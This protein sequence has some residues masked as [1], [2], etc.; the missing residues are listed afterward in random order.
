MDFAAKLRRALTA[1]ELDL[2]YNSREAMLDDIQA[3]RCACVAALPG[4]VALLPLAL[5]ARPRPC[6]IPTREPP[7]L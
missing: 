1:K 2:E 3:A 7:P 4:D 6:L 5:G